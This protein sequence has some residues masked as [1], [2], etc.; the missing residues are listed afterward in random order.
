MKKKQE[1]VQYKDYA[2]YLK[3]EKWKQVKKDYAENEQT[4]Y[5]LCCSEFFNMSVKINFHHFR[6]EN[7]WNN[8]NW[9]NLIVV[10]DDCHTKIHK[11]ID[12]E[13]YISL[14]GYLTK[15]VEFSK[16]RSSLETIKEYAKQISRTSEVTSD[17]R[18]LPYKV[19]I[20]ADTEISGRHLAR[21]VLS[22]QPRL[23]F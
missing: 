14:R 4:E 5:C 13:E 16:F 3:S 20:K 9:E 23:P 8:D 19:I 7:D 2:E 15:L 10:C 21:E 6:Y 22:N 17:T 12:H 18:G 11:N 1:K